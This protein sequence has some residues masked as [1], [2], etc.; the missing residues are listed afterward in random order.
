MK[1]HHLQ[2]N[3]R[4]QEIILVNEI[5]QTLKDKEHIFSYVWSIDVLLK[6]M[7]MEDKICGG[8]ERVM[9]YV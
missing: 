4:R 3:Q 2:E 1:L 6:D 9:K 8:T 7:E 5:S